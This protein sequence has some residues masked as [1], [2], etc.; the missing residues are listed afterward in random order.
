MWVGA[1]VAPHPLRG[2]NEYNTA[3]A[4]EYNIIVPENSLKFEIV[5]PRPDVYDFC[6]MDTIVAF[7]EANGMRLRGHPLVWEQQ[8]PVWVQDLPLSREDWTAMLQDHVTQLVR[9]Y[10]G[11]VQVWDVINEPLTEEGTLKDTLWFQHIGPEYLELALRWAHDADPDARLFINEFAT[12]NLNSKSDALYALAQDLLARGV[13][14]NGIGFQMHLIEPIPPDPAQIA[15]NFR[16]F[17]DL[18]LEVQITELDVRLKEPVTPEELSHQAEIYRMVF[19]ACL[20]AA[21]CDTVV[22]WGVNDRSSWIPYFYDSWGSP[23]ILDDNYEPKP[24]YR[25]IL[26]TLHP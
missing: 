5:H 13:P 20:S 23:L 4:R 17:G 19:E 18:G 12:E 2:T 25:A 3:T 14:L 21:N 6:Q 1:S 15:E 24:A 7:A 9:R 16:R 22:M 11:E 26:E 8:L 10:A